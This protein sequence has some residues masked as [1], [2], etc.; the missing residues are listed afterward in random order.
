MI[1]IGHLCK[2]SALFVDYYLEERREEMHIKLL[3]ISGSPIK[4]GN[5]DAI[6]AE[7]LKA[8]EEMGNVETSMISL[9]GK[10]GLE[11]RDC[12]QCNW[13]LSKQEE[14]KFCQYQDEDVMGEVYPEMV[15]ADGL[16]LASPVYIGRMSG[17]MANLL[18]RL[19]VMVHGNVYKNALKNKVAGA[20]AVSWFRNSG[21]ETTLQGLVM[22]IMTFKMI[23]V[24]SGAG[25]IF[26]GGANA[27]LNGTGK[28][29]P[30]YRHGVL[31]DDFGMNTARNTVRN[32]VELARLIKA[33]KESLQKVKT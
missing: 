21:V 29:D 1:F 28:F 27:T 13:C 4:E 3:G 31:K 22:S 15:E 18:D 12:N 8:G 10:R 7:A 11:L 16:I 17:Y 5:T 24:G 6:L 2:L 26:G 9:Y 14:G 33:G 19:R 32:V 30:E 23:P 20:I 25:C